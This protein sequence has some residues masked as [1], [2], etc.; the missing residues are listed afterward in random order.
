M[1]SY[2]VVFAASMCST[3]ARTVHAVIVKGVVDYADG[4]KNDDWHDYAAYAS[5]AYARRILETTYDRPVAFTQIARTRA[6]QH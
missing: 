3:P 6:D 4:S 2:G 5:A 1:E